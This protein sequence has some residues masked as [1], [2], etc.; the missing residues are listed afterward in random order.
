MT[1]LNE[2]GSGASQVDV[3]NCD[4]CG[5]RYTRQRLGH[6]FCSTSCR[7][8]GN[9]DRAACGGCGL[10]HRGQRCKPEESRSVSV[11]VTLPAHVRRELDAAV[12]WGDRSAFVARAVEAALEGVTR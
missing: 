9:R 7:V 2:V 5:D 11:C 3:G 12:G 10:H 4:H 6:R 1:A 8:M